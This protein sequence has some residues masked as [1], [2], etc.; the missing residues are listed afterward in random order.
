MRDVKNDY[1]PRP[2]PDRGWAPSVSIVI[3]SRNEGKNI[4]AA[5]RSAIEQD[6]PGVREIIVADA[7]STDGTR[8]A[9]AALAATDARVRLIDNEARTTPAGLNAAIR[10]STGEVIVRCD[11]HAALPPGYVTRSV[12]LLA[13]T[14]A[15][16]VGGMQ[17]AR[18]RSLLQ[19]AIAR[20]MSTPMGV[21]DAKFHLGGKAGPVDTVYLGVFRRTALE[22]VGYFDE[23]LKRNQDSELNFRLRATGGVVYFSPELRVD[24]EPRSSVL[25]LWKQYFTSGAWKR[26]TFRRHP[27]AA[28]LRQLIPPVFVLA[29]IG[30]AA[31]AITPLAPIGAIVPS[32]YLG[33]ILLTTVW[34]LL[35]R[36]DIS[37][38]LLPI[39]LPTMHIAWGLG[40]LAGRSGV[41]HV[42]LQAYSQPRADGYRHLIARRIG[43]IWARREVL[44]R[45]V[46]EDLRVKYEDHILGYVWSVLEPMLM[47]GVFWLI[48]AKMFPATGFRG[49]VDPYLLFLVSGI[50]PWT[51]FNTVVTASTASITSNSSLIKKVFLP[52]EIFPLSLVISKTVEFVLSLAVMFVIALLYSV[53]PS[54][55][56]LALPV[57]TLLM[58]VML[59]G[60]A[61]LLSVTNT[62]LRDVERVVRP[63]LRVMFYLSVV[64]FPVANVPV[65]LQK[66]VRLNPLVGIFELIHAIWYPAL[67]PGWGSVLYSA[68]FAV[69]LLF[70]GWI[71]FLRAEPAVL[72]EI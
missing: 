4:E 36:L 16:N 66:I 27:R 62:L 51:W 64:L 10:A 56:L 14:G 44:K 18:G 37:A 70:L 38:L 28:R 55:Y 67:F 21:G 2:S 35:R 6:Y 71:V 47:V 29:L 26:E 54:A 52:R 65:Q 60:I 20:A 1:G 40:L 69:G 57:A 45:I 48:F 59:T 24:Y 23:A 50:L 43:E 30:S 49:G 41:E 46:R 72:K 53:R 15:D 3:P 7:L 8:E 17:V 22:R 63:V 13:E 9:V 61:L 11:G 12:A 5:L 31:F 19:R 34:I 39:V 32:I 42:P 68:V 58:V 25:D 33:A